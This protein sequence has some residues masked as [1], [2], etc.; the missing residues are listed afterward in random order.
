MVEHRVRIII[1]QVR[2]KQALLTVLAGV[3]WAAL[4]GAQARPLPERVQPH[5]VASAVGELAAGLARELRQPAPR[6]DLRLCRAATD[7]AR[8]LPDDATHPGGSLVAE[9]LALH[10]IVEPSPDMMLSGFSPG[11]ERE[12][13]E[14]LRK[15]LR[16]ALAKGRWRLLGVGVVPVS[17]TRL[18]VLVLMLESFIELDPLPRSAPVGEAPIVLRG[19]LLPPFSRPQVLITTPAGQ[20]ERVPGTTDGTRFQA[21]MRCLVRGRYQIE[22]LGED[23][24]GSTVLANFPIYC[25]QEA[26]R[27]L[28]A[29]AGVGGPVVHTAREAEQQLLV[30]LNADRARF[31]LP[32]LV[33]DERLAQ[34][35]RNHSLDMRTGGFVG[36]VSPRTGSARDRV[37]R[38]QIDTVVLLENVARAYSPQQVQQALMDSPGHRANILDKSVT[39]AGIGVELVPS[40]GGPPE[41][42]V[43][44]LLMRPMPPFDSDRVQE[45]TLLRVQALRAQQGLGHLQTDAAL[46]RLAGEIARR[47][48]D[49]QLPAERV[50]EPAQQAL[51]QFAGRY[52]LLRTVLAV[53]N[54]PGELAPAKSLLDRKVT[55][56]GIGAAPVPRTPEHRAAAIYLVLV[57][58]QGW[59]QG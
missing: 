41:L 28:G 34:V 51:G 19:R 32:P 14:G 8:V 18:R 6:L 22:V 20:V 27:E 31:G 47:V 29:P 1:T 48:A 2:L 23:R 17:A 50:G 37:A 4:G 52:R 24:H 42:W 9:A 43:T 49:G 3:A 58:A 25:G 10:G 26:P 40:P 38:A 57:L 44:Q 55:H 15:P 21:T 12:L 59:G 54:D 11:H 39:H 56:I 5:P 30:L 53:T 35:A 33:W 16:E 36:H 7:L 45:Q 46:S 13:L